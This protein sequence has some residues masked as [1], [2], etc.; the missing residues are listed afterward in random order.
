[1]KIIRLEAE[2]L[3]RIKAVDISPT[4]AVVELTGPNDAGKSSVLDA[5][6][7]AL[8]G[9]RTIQQQ[10]IRKGEDKA[11]VK[12]T[13]GADK[14]IELIVTRIFTQ[15]GTHITIEDP[16]GNT[17]A[18]PQKM[19]DALIGELS[20]DPLE[21]LQLAPIEQAKRL[22][23]IVGV[24]ISQLE[25]AQATDRTAQTAAKNAAS[26][27]KSQAATI[28]VPDGL[29]ET[30][31][32]VTDI[33]TKMFAQ[34]DKNRLV[35]NA[36]ERRASLGSRISQLQ[37]ELKQAEDEF[38]RLEEVAAGVVVSVEQLQADLNTADT[39]AKAI[40]RR[41][42]RDDLLQQAKANDDIVD[43]IKLRMEQRVSAFKKQVAA[44]K[45]PVEGLTLDPVRGV[46][47]NEVPFEQASSA[48]QIRVSTAIAMAANPKIKVLRIKEGALLDDASLAAIGEMVTA[49]DY[50]LWVETV[51][52]GHANAIRLEDGTVVVQPPQPTLAV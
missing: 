3:K 31:P 1:M 34:I 39:V 52:S 29:P 49:A 17:F 44:A 6:F 9:G 46:L 35:Q 25:D 45:L 26:L 33:R 10:P 32:D 27:L 37:S 20:F 4:G 12:V 36:I 40:D 30:A 50:Q 48:Q 13:L 7:W 51:D 21:F 15:K 41:K 2:N 18:S 24:D 43:A 47:F 22:Q 16:A 11:R 14:K 38:A 28:V 23:A 42:R 19:L 5:I 8:A